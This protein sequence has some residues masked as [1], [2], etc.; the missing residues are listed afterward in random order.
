MVDDAHGRTLFMELA[1]S[2][3]CLKRFYCAPVLAG[4]ARRQARGVPDIG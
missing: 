2:P 1:S 4:I 3:L